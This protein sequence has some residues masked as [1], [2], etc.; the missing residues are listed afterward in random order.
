MIYPPIKQI[1]QKEAEAV[2]QQE[3]GYA[4][5]K[6]FTDKPIESVFKDLPKSCPYTPNREIAAH[7]L[8]RIS[9]W[10]TQQSDERAPST[11]FR[12]T[13]EVFSKKLSQNGMTENI[14]EEAVVNEARGTLRVLEGETRFADAKGAKLLKGFISSIQKYLKSGKQEATTKP[15]SA[16]RMIDLARFFIASSNPSCRLGLTKEEVEF[17]EQG[18]SFSRA[19]HHRDEIFESFSIQNINY[20]LIN[21][22]K[23]L[24]IRYIDSLK[25]AGIYYQ[26][27]Q[28][29]QT[30]PNKYGSP[31]Q[32]RKL[33]MVVPGSGNV[34]SPLVLASRLID[35]KSIDSAEFI[36]TE[37]NP[38]YLG[39]IDFELKWL[40]KKGIITNYRDPTLKKFNGGKE[41]AEYFFKFN[42]QG[43]EI[44]LLYGVNRS[45]KDWWNKKYLKEIDF[46][47]FSDGPEKNDYQGLREKLSDDKTP[48]STPYLIVEGRYS[49]YAKDGK[50]EGD[51][52][53]SL[54]YVEEIQ[55]QYG[56]CEKATLL[57]QY[58]PL[59]YSEN[60]FLR[61]EEGE[62]QYKSALIV[63]ISN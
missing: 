59:Q 17:F 16:D 11:F 44:T 4:K 46:A 43:K 6:A 15:W 56:H 3:S 49:K 48:G 2:S 25:D 19:D 34:L 35:S 24:P 47:V 22:M 40:E 23:D 42:Y 21:A 54:P 30:D 33:K 27:A 13:F 58:D 57:F 51:I 14:L 32:D 12:A 53:H 60:I 52:P 7:F 45:G 62:C 26:F 41:G 28:R 37:L 9:G 55:G 18:V 8:R 10:A 61:V 31:I 5:F 1:R 50:K 63:P 39:R 38:N 29:I 20:P 36:Y